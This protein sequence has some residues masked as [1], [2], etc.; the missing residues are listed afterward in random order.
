MCWYFRFIIQC[1]NV[2][3]S[4]KERR[5]TISNHLRKYLFWYSE[6]LSFF[7]ELS[8]SFP[9]HHTSRNETCYIP[10][11]FKQIYEL[12]TNVELCHTLLDSQS[13]QFL[14]VF[15]CI[16]CLALPVCLLIIG[17]WCFCI[18]F[19]N[20]YVLAVIY[21]S[22]QVIYTVLQFRLAVASPS[23][24]GKKLAYSCQ[25]HFPLT[26][27]RH[28]TVRPY[29]NQPEISSSPLID[30]IHCSMINLWQVLNIFIQSPCAPS[31]LA[32]F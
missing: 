16:Y 29:V 18:L 32:T 4:C 20:F 12:P 19:Y 15:S 10:R 6:F 7:L 14:N 1:S 31:C 11:N 17:L 22:H 28:I 27:S 24:R 5:A 25:Q 23:M 30:A 21:H 3:V 13:W 26:Y 8:V 2:R 9:S